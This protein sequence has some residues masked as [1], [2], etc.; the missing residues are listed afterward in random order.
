MAKDFTK[1]TLEGVSKNLNK[2][3]LVQ[4]VIEVYCQNTKPNYIELKAVWF[5]DMQ[6]GKGVVRLLSEIDEKNERNYYIDAPITLEDGVK[7]VVCNQWGKDNLSN[8]IYMAGFQG[9]KIV[10][11]NEEIESSEKVEKTVEVHEEVDDTTVFGSP[12]WKVPQ[13][14]AF[15]IRHA[16][17]A[18]NEVLEEE[19][20]FMQVAYDEFDKENIN[21]KDAWDLVDDQAQLYE[22][23]GFYGTMLV[24]VVTFLNKN[25]TE[26]QKS[27]LLAILME[28]C[29]QDNV[30][31][32]TEYV[33][34][35]LIARTFYPG[36]ERALINERFEAA[37]I[38]IE[39]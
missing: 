21:I 28:I 22:Q 5:D 2:A 27:T 35:I 32:R 14:L 15:I 30:I 34:L 19:L 13:S 37:G 31:R 11:E 8:F 17:L 1:Y 4:K 25:L 24:N 6:G 20:E 23:M 38:Q 36:E 9:F 18:D 10:A 7:V 33:T 16:I 3:R 26:K 29:A 12:G 39:E